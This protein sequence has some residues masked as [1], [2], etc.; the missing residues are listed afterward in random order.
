[1]LFNYN[2]VYYNKECEEKR[3]HQIVE[4]TGFRQVVFIRFNPDGYIDE[5]TGNKVKSCWS[6][7]KT[8]L[9]Q[10]H[11][12]KEVEWNLRLETLSYILSE[13]LNKVP[14]DLIEII[15]IFK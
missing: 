4:D 1:M 2:H 13:W 11:K 9:L 6:Y 3:I 15:N 12:H 14:K 10:L 7:T 8:G 5:S